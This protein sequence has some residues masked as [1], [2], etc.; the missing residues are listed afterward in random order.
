MCRMCI[1]PIAVAVQ[2][3]VLGRLSRDLTPDDLSAHA[4]ES[5][6]GRAN[7][8]CGRTIRT[9]ALTIITAVLKTSR[10]AYANDQS[11]RSER[12]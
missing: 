10:D 1:P 8:D 6:L 4:R 2:V 9:P 12:S 3:Q 11:F 5:H 7:Y